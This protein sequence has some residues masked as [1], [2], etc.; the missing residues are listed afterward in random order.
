M[1]NSNCVAYLNREDTLHPRLWNHSCHVL[2]KVNQALKSI[3]ESDLV[4]FHPSDELS[5]LDFG[6][7]DRPY[8]PWFQEKR[9][10]YIAADV[11]NNLLADIHF[12]TNRPIPIESDSINIVFSTSVLEHVRD[13]E[14]YLSECYRVLKSDGVLILSA[15]GFWTWHGYPDDFYRW[16]FQGMH[17]VIEQANFKVEKMTPCVG[18]LAYTTH[19]RNQLLRGVLYKL[20]P[21]SW[22]VIGLLNIFSSLL[23]PLEDAITPKTVLEQNAVMHVLAARKVKVDMSVETD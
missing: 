14:G 23:M 15:P 3:L 1:T 6:C 12:D 21:I 2:K 20:T 5:V 4:R 22:P 19:L 9:M 11:R 16:T 7:G 8:E 18:P 13:V 17:A 10:Q